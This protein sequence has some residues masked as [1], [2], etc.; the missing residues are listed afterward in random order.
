MLRKEVYFIILTLCIPSVLSATLHVGSGQTY[1]TIQS[2][3]DA[4]SSGDT[5]KVH[6]GTYHETVSISK[7]DLTI[8]AYDSNNPPELDG[9]DQD[10]ANSAH[11]WMHVQGKIYRTTYDLPFPHVTP[12]EF[13]TTGTGTGRSGDRV[14]TLYEDDIWLRGY[15]GGSWSELSRPYNTLADLDPSLDTEIGERDIRIPG[16]FMYNDTTNQLYVWT[17]QEHGEDHPGNHKYYIPVLKN[18][19][20]INAPRVTLRNLVLKHSYYYA[21]EVKSTGDGSTI[22]GCYI[23]NTGPWAIYSY[24]ARNLIIHNNLIQ[25]RGFYE[26]QDY[27][28]VR[29]NIL[30]GHLIMVKGLDTARN[31]DISGNVV[32]GTYSMIVHGQDCRVHDNI[33]SKS[34]SVMVFPQI[35]STS[36][37]PPDGY[38]HNV[39]IYH[40]ILHHSGYS[41]FSNYNTLSSD[42]N[43]YYGPI[44]FYRNVIYAVRYINK[45]GCERGPCDPTPDT[46][47]YHNTF[48]FNKLM[49]HHSY[50]YPVNKSTVYRNNIVQFRHKGMEMYWAYTSSD[51][52]LERGW[53]YFPFDNGPDSDYNI[54]W[55]QPEWVWTQ[56]ARFWFYYWDGEKMVKDSGS[57]TYFEGQF[58]QMQSET[59]IDPNSVE[60]DPEFVHGDEFGTANVYNMHYDQFSYMDYRDV[61]SQGY[62]NLFNQHFAQLYDYF[63]V[64]TETS[65]AIDNGVAIPSTWPDI[66]TITDGKPD[67]GAKEYGSTSCIEEWSCTPWSAW[68]TCVNNQQT[69]TRTCT[70]ANNCGT[71]NNKPPE[72]ETSFCGSDL[73]TWWSFDDISG[74]TINDNSAN[75]ND[76]TMQG[77]PQIVSGRINNAIGLDGD[78]YF[79]A[80]DSA[81]LD[82][83]KSQGTIMMWVKPEN[84]VSSVWQLFAIDSDYEIE[85]SI[86]PD[87]DLFYYPWFDSGPNQNYNLVTNPLTDEWKHIAVTWDYSTKDVRIY[88]NGQEM[89]LAVDNVPAN[90]DT[91]AQTGD[92]HIGGSPVKSE[93]FIGEIDEVK[94]FSRPLTQ[95]EI[96]EHYDCHEADSDCSGC[97]ET[98]ELLA[99]IELWKQNQVAI[100]ELMDAIAVWKSCS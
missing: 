40:N 73:I 28:S 48:V 16:R 83:D 86:Q 4:A 72:I 33:I 76:A 22:E 36:R 23:I 46:F 18:L 94:I 43:K 55:R 87:G 20:I 68:S 61:I 63:N 3:V 30:K 5:I 2:A 58:S 19:I 71:T 27:I 7:S 98:G 81:S 44:W 89:T 32:T 53:S 35:E 39:S 57:K 96:E 25:L 11:T 34:Q 65:P 6:P 62:T 13:S 21:I 88:V 50:N 97:V 15:W 82:F 9:A 10:F 41:A 52:T 93:Y 29:H 56:I 12:T 78:D 1:S 17:A 91:I 47:V 26:R 100:G 42:R 77:N 37:T 84:P 99:Y 66:V 31:C 90:W 64:D 92:W 24:S 14:M 49:A 67:I 95:S 60:A 75:S 85:L 69:R 70:D 45:D 79:S 59:G 38:I 8:E 80:D 54:Y 74:T 51:F